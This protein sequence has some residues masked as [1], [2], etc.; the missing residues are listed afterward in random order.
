MSQQIQDT[1]EAAPSQVRIWPRVLLMGTSY[2]LVEV[3]AALILQPETPA[4]LGFGF[5]WSWLL[6]AA[7]LALP[8]LG[9]RIFYGVTYYFSAIWVLAQTGYDQLFHKLMW[10]SDI[11]YAG[12]G[13]DYLD[14]V[15]TGFSPV[16]WIGLVV[17][18][19]RA[20]V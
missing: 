9:G 1:Q 16:W 15:L 2:F 18:I 5:L 17:Q 13:A 11:F 14:T 19:G 3:F 20:H 4:G 10:L 6:T 12:E 8:R 7:A